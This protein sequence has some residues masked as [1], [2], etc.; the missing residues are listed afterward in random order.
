M[1]A[2]RTTTLL[3]AAAWLSSCVVAASTTIPNPVTHA[4]MIATNR[5]VWFDHERAGYFTLP[6]AA[7]ANEASLLVLDSQRACFSVTLRVESGQRQLATPQGWRVF[8]RGSGGFENMQ[9]IFGPPAS[10]YQQTFPGSIPRQQFMGYYTDCMRMGYGMNCTQR[11]RY[12]VVREPA[13]I[14]TAT[15]ASS[16]CFAHGGQINGDTS[17]ITLHLDAP[18]DVTRRL[19]FRWQLRR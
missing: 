4:G 10:Q 13:M 18:D 11:P 5:I 17:E 6:T 15:G 9:P 1:D 14:T 16:V 19:A 8:L 2:L 12:A 3:S 7:F